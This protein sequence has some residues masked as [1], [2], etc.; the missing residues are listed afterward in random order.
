MT[1][2]EQT[3]LGNTLQSWSLAL[4][5]AIGL[6]AGLRLLRTVLVRRFSAFAERT[7]AGV[8]DLIAKLLA[9][10]RFS[11]LVVL[12]LYAGSL[13]LTLSKRVTDVIGAVTMIVVL[14]QVAI[15]GNAVIA[16]WITRYRE[17]YLEED[18][19]GVTTAN[20]LSFIARLTLFTLVG[21]LA[22]DN[23]PGV[24]VTTL[25][26]GLGVGGIA[27]ALAVQNIIGDL[28]ASLS[29]A[30]DKPFIIGDFIVVDGFLGTVEH[31]G[32]RSTRI[33]SV[34]GEQ[35]IFANN[36]LLSS[37]IRNFKRMYERR[38]VFS[39][40]VIYQTPY[41]KLVKIPSMVREII[42][43]QEQTRFDRAHFKEYGDF[44][45]NFEVVYYVLDPD[46]KLHMDIQQA[47]NLAIFH[48]FQEEGIEF[49]YPTQTLLI[50]N[51]RVAALAEA[52][53]AAVGPGRD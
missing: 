36:D 32:L 24:E 4:V 11:F 45:L 51:G 20:T 3:F 50:G 23:I 46:Y 28:F 6:L 37:R 14:V 12:A 16:F 40:G 10:T 35:L 31:I 39:F 8:D 44:S 52:G 47:I 22:L 5:I 43:S 38:G 7:E 2:L 42:E 19:A 1:F 29:I 41:E 9:K 21:L 17:R 18:A 27:V 34:S 53:Q 26:A 13:A 15:W 33:R 49:A 25:I 30:L 48:R